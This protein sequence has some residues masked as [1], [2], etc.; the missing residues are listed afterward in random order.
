MSDS[1]A[2]PP[3]VEAVV[4]VTNNA[5]GDESSQ[6]SG[7]RRSSRIR[8]RQESSTSQLTDGAT[9]DA[10][11]EGFSAD[12]GLEHV[13]RPIGTG[14]RMSLA[15]DHAYTDREKR[16]MRR[17]IQERMKRGTIR[18]ALEE[19]RRKLREEMR[20]SMFVEENIEL[21]PTLEKT[22]PASKDAYSQARKEL[23]RY[24]GPTLQSMENIGDFL[25]TYVET[26]NLYRLSQDQ[27]S[28]LLLPYFKG[29]MGVG[30]R[31]ILRKEGLRRT[32]NYLRQFKCQSHSIAECEKAMLGWKLNK[33]QAKASI[34]DL[35]LATTS[36]YPRATAD[37]VLELTKLRVKEYISNLEDLARAEETERLV[38]GYPLNL[39]AFIQEVERVLGKQPSTPEALDVMATAV[40]Q[41]SAPVPP[42]PTPPPQPTQNGGNN[43]E[44]IQ[45]FKEMSVNLQKVI[46]QQTTTPSSQQT[47]PMIPQYV[48]ITMPFQP[49][50]SLPSPPPL[51]PQGP[52]GQPPLGSSNR[53]DQGRNNGKFA[54]HFVREDS[55][56]F[57]EATTKFTKEDLNK[58]LPA[59]PNHSVPYIRNADGTIEPTPGAS[60]K[61]FPKKLAIF[62]YDTNRHR[63][64]LTRAVKEHFQ[65][66]C[67]TCG[68]EGHKNASVYCPMQAV[69]DS[70]TLCPT[71][72][73]GFHATCTYS[74]SFIQNLQQPK[75]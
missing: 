58:N 61:M 29:S 52:T 36:A 70:W 39:P 6:A 37:Q 69:G 66:R 20:Q 74:P 68:L 62:G 47:P 45:A 26:V 72:N 46:A 2:D 51:P 14:T 53:G 50:M 33:R 42:Q 54:Y 28:R 63:F 40:M 19:Q 59:V 10:T 32:L 22:T 55:P 7:V 15:P 24:A 17:T 5:S 71:C 38:T 41:P 65:T 25:N 30:V 44:L 1:N 11:E 73:L 49:P 56:Q 12:E 75:N 67:A 21:D 27:A 64:N 16:K 13:L 9:T 23:G 31:A 18:A 35:Y 43:E 57:Q 8:R 48:P 34:F 3:P 4:Q 60:I